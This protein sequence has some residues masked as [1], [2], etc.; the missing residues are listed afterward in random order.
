M[1]VTTYRTLAAL[2]S[3]EI[4]V[5]RSVFRCDL[6]RVEDEA[7]AR[8]FV[9]EVRR[10]AP[11]ARHHCTAFIL[12]PDRLVERSNDDGEPSGTAGAP[13]LEAL[14]GAEV[15]DV[16]AVVTRWFGGVLLGTGGLARAYAD[17]VNAALTQ[18][19]LVTRT[20]LT[21]CEADLP[22]AV[23]ARTEH[24]VRTAGYR[25][26]TQTYG[27]RE[28]TLTLGADSSHTDALAGVLA[29]AAHQPIAVREL[30]PRWVD[31]D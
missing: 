3:A 26:L 6:A 1:S 8:D 31:I 11:E 10:R 14:R 29:A 7:A 19:T 22:I 23:A 2:A 20:R 24:A 15:S 25:V 5:K 30:S 9:A 17:A 13:M 4:E 16:V 28:V 12:G 27:A 18:A 21:V